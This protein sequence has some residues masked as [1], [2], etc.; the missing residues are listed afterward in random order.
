MS[1]VFDEPQNQYKMSCLYDSQIRLKNMIKAE[2]CMVM[3]MVDPI[4]KTLVETQISEEKPMS[5]QNHIQ[6][7]YTANILLILKESQKERNLH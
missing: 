4:K 3:P 1:Y 5:K 2:S 6:Q 7:S